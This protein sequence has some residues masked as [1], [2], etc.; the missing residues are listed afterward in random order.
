MLAMA[1]EKTFNMRLSDDEATRLEFVSEHYGI[2]AAAI[3][4]ML[5]KK[6]ADHLAAL[7]INASAPGTVE[8]VVSW[9]RDKIPNFTP[10]D[11]ARVDKLFREATEENTKKAVGILRLDQRDTAEKT[12]KKT[13]KRSK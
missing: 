4:R 6:E 3:F 11:A 10:E 2:N 8:A 7:K 13:T 9:M 1:R 5:L 12:K